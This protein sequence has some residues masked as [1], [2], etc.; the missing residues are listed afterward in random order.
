MANFTNILICNITDSNIQ[1]PN[2][3]DPLRIANSTYEQLYNTFENEPWLSSSTNNDDFTQLKMLKVDRDLLF[4]VLMVEDISKS[5]QSQLDDLSTKI[6]PKNQRVD[7][8]RQ[9]KGPKKFNI[10]TQVDLD[11]DDNTTNNNNNNSA[12]LSANFNTSKSSDLQ[13]RKTVYKITLQSKKGDIFFAINTYPIH[14]DNCCWGAKLI[15]KK[16]T[17]FNRG[18][19]YLKENLTSMCF[20]SINSWMEQQDLKKFAYLE[21][22]LNRDNNDFKETTTSRKRKA[23]ELTEDDI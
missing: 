8:L 18:V 12:N 21:G 9:S 11:K 13:S 14:W 20:G 19:F 23:I 5:K 17:I 16:D 10:I 22:K 7:T 6:N 15:I 1:I 3:N 4:Q 2:K